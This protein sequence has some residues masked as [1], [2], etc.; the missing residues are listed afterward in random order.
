M[1]DFKRIFMDI[2]P[3]VYF[4]D[5]ESIFH[6]KTKNVF[7][8][9]FK[10][11]CEILT[12]VITCTEYLVIPY[13]ENNQANINSFW[14]FVQ[15]CNVNICNI[16]VKIAEKAAKIRANYLG[17]KAFDS[18]QIAAACINECDIFLT[19]DKQLRQYDEIKCIT[20]EEWIIEEN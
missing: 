19:N 12:S 8:Y 11:D 13:R 14:Q 5:R 18:M 10:C 1:R 16:D 17:F 7:N 3:I 9:I 4:L 15:Q 20:V 6:E 2:A